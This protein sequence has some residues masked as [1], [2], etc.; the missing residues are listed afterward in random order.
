[1]VGSLQVSRGEV[2]PHECDPGKREKDNQ[3]ETRHEIL[4]AH[5]TLFPYATQRMRQQIKTLSY[6]VSGFLD[7]LMKTKKK[8]KSVKN[9]RSRKERL[10]VIHG[11]PIRPSRWRSGHRT[12]GCA[13]CYRPKGK[14]PPPEK[15]LCKEHRRPILRQRWWSGYRTKGCALCFEVPEPDDRLCR[16][17]DQAILPSAW[18]RG[19]HSTGCSRCFNS[20]PGYAAAQARCRARA[21]LRLHRGK[22]KKQ[23]RKR[24]RPAK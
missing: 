12:T 15:R 6:D 16:K 23:G 18:I 24:S 21:K 10:C 4:L 8:A 20:R 1:M 2:Q 3:D 22:R 17:H 7:S 9:K 5:R 13:D 19:R 14:M 11:R